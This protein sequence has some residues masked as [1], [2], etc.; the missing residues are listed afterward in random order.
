[1]RRTSPSPCSVLA[2]CIYLSLLTAVVWMAIA[3]KSAR[4]SISLLLALFPVLKLRIE[5]PRVRI[6]GQAY[7]VNGSESIVEITVKEKFVS[8]SSCGGEENLT[9]RNLRRIGIAL[10]SLCCLVLSG[11]FSPTLKAQ[12]VLPKPQPPFKGKIERMAK[13]RK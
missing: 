10:A 12:D 11:V 7:V 3:I 1:M 13:E 9:R 6:E 8:F 5:E 2:E 4:G